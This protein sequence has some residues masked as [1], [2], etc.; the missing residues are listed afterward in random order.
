MKNRCVWEHNGNDTLLYSS[1]FPGAFTRGENA[2]AALKKMEREI[3][4]YLRWLNLPGTDEPVF[5][6]IVQ[7]KES[8]LTI[9]DAD[10]DILFDSEKEPLPE[11]EYWRLKARALRSA[12]DF[13]TLYQSIPDPNQLLFPRRKTFY[14]EIPATAEEIYQHTKNV[15]CYYFGEIGVPASNDGTILTCR[16][17][18]FQL[19]EQQDGFLQNRIFSGS[20]GEDWNV[21]KVLRRFIWHDRIHA[22]ALWK[23]AAQLFGRESISDP[24]LMQGRAE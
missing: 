1:D 24:Y 11:K 7:Q 16:E 3:H 2:E 5:S 8:S 9:R 20:Y 13:L 15:N 14:G 22:R 23:A 19:L 21:K 10:S 17:E 6:E 18:G 4:S 12:E